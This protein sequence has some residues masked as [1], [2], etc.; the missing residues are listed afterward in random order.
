MRLKICLAAAVFLVCSPPALHCEDCRV[1]IFINPLKP[2]LGLI[3]IGVE[4]QFDPQYSGH[5]SAEYAVFRPGYLERIKH[6]D[7]VWSMGVRHYF[8][9]DEPDASGLFSGALFGQTARWREGGKGWE[10][11][12]G[13]ELGY[14]FLLDH[15]GYISPRGLV[16]YP[17]ESGKLLPG[18]EALFGRVL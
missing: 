2:F 3:N 14:R 16:S 8:S 4:C 5:L 6:P 12:I 15:S 9:P 11:F 7:F 1:S 10:F 13:A 18:A 17:L